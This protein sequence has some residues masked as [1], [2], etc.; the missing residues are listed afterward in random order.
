MLNAKRV[1]FYGSRMASVK[2]TRSHQGEA[3]RSMR[4][5]V[6]RAHIRAQVRALLAAT[7]VCAAH[8]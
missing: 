4:E 3:R 6:R 1:S 5:A 7:H 8:L 2:E